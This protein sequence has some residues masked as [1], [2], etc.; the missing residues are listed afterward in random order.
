MFTEKIISIEKNK[1]FSYYIE[2]VIL[3]I[4]VKILYDMQ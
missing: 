2:A 3:I 1:K 4:P